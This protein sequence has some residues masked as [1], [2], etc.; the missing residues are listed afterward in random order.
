MDVTRFSGSANAQAFADYLVRKY[1]GTKIDTIITVNPAAVEFLL[2]EAIDV[3]P[4][5]T[6]VANQMNRV[7]AGWRRP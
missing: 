1:A 2:G 6:V 3:F 5:T 7:Y 4:G